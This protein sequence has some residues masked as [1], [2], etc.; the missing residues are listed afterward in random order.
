MA[1]PAAK[2]RKLFCGLELQFISLKF[3]SP[4]ILF[5]YLDF[6]SFETES[7]STEE[8]TQLAALRGGRKGQPALILREAQNRSCAG[9]LPWSG[10]G[11]P[12]LC[13]GGGTDAGD[14]L[15][16]S[17]VWALKHCLKFTGRNEAELSAWCL[18]TF[19]CAK[20][21]SNPSDL[22]L[23]LKSGDWL[24]AQQGW[25]SLALCIPHLLFRLRAA[26]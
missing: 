10:L 15:V 17:R 1:D 16:G 8:S 12:W 22:P 24:N 19:L 26:F 20:C 4:F 25:K 7:T 11:E 2:S 23:E 13:A 21:L 9:P 3:S 14:V 18:K 6:A 5:H